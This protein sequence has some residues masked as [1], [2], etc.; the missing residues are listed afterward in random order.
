MS[1]NPR[2]DIVVSESRL[3]DMG[4]FMVR[5]GS[6]IDMMQGTYNSLKSSSKRV[7][8]SSSQADVTAVN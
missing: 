6:Y 8:R 4:S 3:C 5:P 1:H 7:R 2:E